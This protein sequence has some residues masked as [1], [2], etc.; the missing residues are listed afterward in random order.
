MNL[1]PRLPRIYKR[2]SAP[3]A[4]VGLRASKDGEAGLSLRQFDKPFMQGRTRHIVIRR[5]E[6]VRPV[7]ELSCHRSSGPRYT[8]W[9]K[10][11]RVSDL[12]GLAFPSG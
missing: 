10:G 12:E 4:F 2:T 8:Y 11:G 3:Y 7:A 9:N 6:P 1:A 5:I